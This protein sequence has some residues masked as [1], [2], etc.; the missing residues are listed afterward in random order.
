[1]SS[2]PETIPMM[3]IAALLLCFAPALPKAD[4]DRGIPKNG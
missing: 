1:M 3:T 2:S 4:S